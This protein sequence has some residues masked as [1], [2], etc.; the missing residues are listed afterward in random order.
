[1]SKFNIP[2]GS[3]CLFP[4]LLTYCIYVLANNNRSDNNSTTTRIQNGSKATKQNL[5]FYLLCRPFSRNSSFSKQ[6]LV[7]QVNP[8]EVRC[9][10]VCMCQS[11]YLSAIVCICVPVSYCTA[12]VCAYPR[13]TVCACMSTC[14]H[15]KIHVRWYVSMHFCACMHVHKHTYVCWYVS[16]NL[17]VRRSVFARVVCTVCVR[18]LFK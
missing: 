9:V 12:R 13:V 16:M 5:F 15:T 6:C 14:A 4:S 18:T 7:H 8:K 3:F 1:M 2:G 10:C 11:I 17:C